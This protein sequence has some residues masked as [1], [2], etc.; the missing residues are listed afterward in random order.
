MKQ[1]TILGVPGFWMYEQSG[2]LRP[3][4]E[5]YLNDKPL[6]E[7]GMAT[8]R[9]YLRQWIMADVWNH[10]PGGP[11]AE[12]TALRDRVDG[13]TTQEA[14]HKWIYDALEIGIDPL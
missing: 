11:S 12:L 4:V 9:A 3:V 5:A 14:I 1:P 6:D 8:M 10:A 13:L 2:V 7:R